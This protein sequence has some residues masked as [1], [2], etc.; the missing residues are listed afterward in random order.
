[1]IVSVSLKESR[2]AAESDE[3]KNESEKREARLLSGP[4]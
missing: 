4:A 3:E 2:L 1:M